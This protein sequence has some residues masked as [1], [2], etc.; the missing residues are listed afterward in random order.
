MF[1]IQVCHIGT[2]WESLKFLPVYQLL[3]GKNE[4]SSYFRFSQALSLLG[5]GSINSL[6]A[7]NSKYPDPSPAARDIPVHSWGEESPTPRCLSTKGNSCYLHSWVSPA[8]ASTIWNNKYFFEL[9]FLYFYFIKEVWGII[10]K[11]NSC[12]TS[13]ISLYVVFNWEKN[14]HD[15]TFY[16]DLFNPLIISLY[17]NCDR[18]KIT[19]GWRM[20]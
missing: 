16:T 3:R 1:V 14:V 7:V 5:L 18:N 17:I 19:A 10:Q 13:P 6:N 15:R 12:N 20:L 9:S 4:S 8:S 11:R 2:N